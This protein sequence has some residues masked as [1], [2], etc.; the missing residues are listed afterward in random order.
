MIARPVLRYHG[1][2]WR[3]A[4]W[5]IGHLPPHRVYV[6]PFAGACSVLLRKER[7]YSEVLNDLDDEVVNVFR[8]LRDPV[9]A[10]DLVRL[11]Q[12]TPY[13][14]AEFFD[15]FRA[16]PDPLERARRTMVRYWF[17]FGAGA[18]RT[19]GSTGF[20]ADGAR[21]GTTP[22]HDWMGLPDCLAH[23][24][25]RLRGVL[26]DNEPALRC[27]ARRDAPGTLFYV[28]PPYLPST[29]SGV[30]GANGRTAVYIHELTEADHVELLRTLAGLAGMVILSGYDSDL[31][32]DLLTTWRC[33]RRDVR[34]DGGCA[35]VESLWLNPAAVAATSQ[36]SILAGSTST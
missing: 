9:L 29:R 12:L 18:A 15:C 27:I 4:P 20:R 30:N 10:P 21:A 22:S 28:D 3:M 6:E 33:I 19:V 36:L 11:L 34:G 16:T 35:R 2:K 13:A 8:V 5:I 24:T 26:I 1:G 23:V 17:G 7:S 32:R 31:Y 25:G 14:R